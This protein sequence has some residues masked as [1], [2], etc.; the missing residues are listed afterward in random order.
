LERKKKLAYL[1]AAPRVSTRM[2]AEASGPRAHILGVVQSFKLL[3]WEVKAYIVGDLMP[4]ALIADSEFWLNQSPLLRLGADLTRLVMGLFHGFK[5]W[6]QFHGK[7]DWIYERFATLQSLGWVFRKE[8]VPWILETNGLFYYEA[9]IERKSIVLSRVARILELWAYRH[10]DVLIC[11]TDELKALIVEEAQISPRKILVMPNGVDTER[12]DPDRCTPIHIFDG[13]TIGFVGA[14]LSWQRLDILLEAL[15]ELLSVGI[16]FNLV[17]VGDGPMQKAWKTQAEI[18]GIEDRTRFLGRIPWDDVPAF[19][20]GFG[21]GYVGNGPLEIGKMYHSPLKLY[22]YMAMG[23]PVVA[24]A[25]SD[26]LEMVIPGENGYLFKP[27]DK[28]DLKRVL[29]QAYRDRSYWKEMGVAARKQV[30]EHASWISRVKKAQN[31]IERILH[32][33]K[34]N[35]NQEEK[36]ASI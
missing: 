3:G 15:A 29:G 26:A 33:S 34:F 27:N 1:S 32:E 8:G 14:L 36:K 35:R 6:R 11:V 10:C 19:I 12:F 24:S 21:L 17:V 4:R 23:L 7:V 30:L 9:K 18:L 22:E 25:Y 28:E 16:E 13:P 5:V 20:S 2:D 31:E